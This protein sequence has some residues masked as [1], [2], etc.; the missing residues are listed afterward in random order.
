MREID[1]G[2]Q[3]KNWSVQKTDKKYSRA[4]EKLLRERGL[5]NSSFYFIKKPKYCI[6]KS[7]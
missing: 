2:M 3:M 7:I 5:E 1:K 4:V 6:E